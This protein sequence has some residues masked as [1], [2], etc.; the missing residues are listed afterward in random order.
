MKYIL[1]IC[2]LLLMTLPAL[3]DLS[4]L[5]LTLPELPYDYE[6]EIEEKRFLHLGDF[7]EPPTRGQLIYFWTFNTLDVWTTHRGIK[8]SPLI[9]EANPLLDDR[10]SLEEL[11]LQK[12][13][14]GGLLHKHSSSDYMQVLNISLTWAVWNNYDIIYN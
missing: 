1:P 4:E 13:I 10:P 7:N 6:I 11:I 2:A 3:S 9:K 5:D 14:V 8:H 12:A